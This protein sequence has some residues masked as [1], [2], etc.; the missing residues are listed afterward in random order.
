MKCVA[1]KII[2]IKIGF[3]RGDILRSWISSKCNVY[4]AKFLVLAWKDPVP[5]QKIFC[6]PEPESFNTMGK[7]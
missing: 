5:N 6:L 2:K 3:G 1:L 4:A 7:L